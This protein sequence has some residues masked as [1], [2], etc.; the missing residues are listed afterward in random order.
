MPA[1]T[2][3]RALAKSQFFHQFFHE[4]FYFATK[5]IKKVL[6]SFASDSFLFC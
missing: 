4:S 6:D 2:E 1:A 3:P 5:G